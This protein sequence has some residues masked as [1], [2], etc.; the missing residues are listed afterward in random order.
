M[1]TTQ[2]A[3][4][5][6][7]KEIDSVVI[8]FCG[9]SGDGMQLAGGQFAATSAILGNDIAT[10]PDFPAE[11]RAPRGT[12][13]GVSGFQLQFSS[14]DINTPGDMVNALI[15]M[16]P[17][18]LK[19]N[20][21][22]VVSGG[23]VIANADEFTEVNLRKCGYPPG[24][25]PLEDDKLKSQYQIVGVPMS[26]LTREALEGADMTV[27]EIDRCRNMFALGIAY[28]LFDRDLE[29][30]IDHIN[31]Y[32]GVIKKRPEVAE[33]NVKALKAGYYFGENAE[34]FP[35]RYHVSP[36]KLE[37]GVYR[38]ISGNQ[39]VVK[40]LATIANKSGV[41]LLYASYPITP[42]SDILHDL[43]GLKHLGVRTFQAEDE[44]AAI[45][46]AI[47]ASFAGQIG[48]TGTSGPGL[49]LK[50]E[51][52][53]MAVIYELPLIVIDVQR[54]G[55]S[56]GMPTKTEQADL[57]QALWGRPG[58]SPCLVLAARSPADCF[59]TTLEAARLAIKHM[60][61][62]IVLS[63]GYIA[64]GAEPWKIPDLNEIDPIEIKFAEPGDNGEVFLGYRRDP[65]TLA[66]PWALPGT[67]GLE[68]RIGSL[69]KQDLTG[70]VSYDPMNHEKMVKI[71]A[72][73]VQRAAADIAP[74]PIRGSDS[75]GTLLLG[76]GSTYGA[77]ATA[78][79]RLRGMGKDVSS[80]HIRNIA[81]L[82]PDLG[83]ILARFDRVIIPEIN[84]GQLLTLIRARYLIDARGINHIRGRAFKVDDL[85]RS[86]LDIIESKE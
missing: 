71:R 48:V 50:T 55:P 70:N 19:V 15:A 53:G 4:Q 41:N 58:E 73:K 17:A 33:A 23:I 26:R 27:K 74:T 11:I 63:D 59:D 13:F 24:Y 80:A 67:P 79:D 65:E 56:T 16:N 62:A 20:I 66:R 69:E 8:R 52:L 39:A 72:E 21:D 10:F 45:C 3:R 6:E 51:A 84:M 49:A 57:F 40:A 36:A 29:P 47:G 35:A 28:W 60:C 61:P 5:P 86:V 34:L 43:S 76:W 68:H 31:E 32:Y 44:I 7:P 81:P 22:D 25:N 2:T 30:T 42:A 85:V 14:T 77:I 54:A 12:T 46:A 1:T 18:G 38:Q 75:G 82:P 78:T 83:D 64:N 9:D 37:P